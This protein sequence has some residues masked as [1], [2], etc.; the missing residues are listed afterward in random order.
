MGS[1][2]HA[3]TGTDLSDTYGEGSV[4]EVEPRPLDLPTKDPAVYI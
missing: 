2:I 4:K 1:E 3:D